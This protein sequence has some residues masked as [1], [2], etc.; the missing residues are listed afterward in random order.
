[1]S[2]TAVEFYIEDDIYKHKHSDFCPPP[3][4]WK[5]VRVMAANVAKTFIVPLWATKCF[6]MVAPGGTDFWANYSAAATIPSGDVSDGSAAELNPAGRTVVGGQAISV[7]TA[8]AGAIIQAY[9][10]KTS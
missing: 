10:Y 4:G 1:M 8:T 5:D 2:G 7:I 6:L 3:S 9:Y